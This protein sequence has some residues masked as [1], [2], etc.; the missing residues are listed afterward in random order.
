MATLPRRGEG[1]RTMSFSEL[2]IGALVLIHAAF[3]FFIL[4]G[5]AASVFGYFRRS[6]W[7]GNFKFRTVHFLAIFFVFTRTW[8]GFPC[9]LS[10]WENG[11]RESAGIPHTGAIGAVFHSF[12]FR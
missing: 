12:A 3:S 10:V 9:P 4:F 6:P 1:R 8:L 2:L 5:V 11:L 7:T